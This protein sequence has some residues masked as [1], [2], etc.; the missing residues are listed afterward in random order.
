MPPP[1]PGHS[2][3]TTLPQR[4]DWGKMRGRGRQWPPHPTPPASPSQTAGMLQSS[5]QLR[6]AGLASCQAHT[7]TGRPWVGVLWG[8][9]VGMGL[10]SLSSL[11]PPHLS[12]PPRGGGQL[13]TAPAP[14]PPQCLSQTR[15][16]L[17]ES[18]RHR[19]ARRHT[20]PGLPRQWHWEQ[21]VHWG[22]CARTGDR[23]LSTM[24]GR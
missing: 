17:V 20:S 22:G 11:L 7:A 15:V 19:G 16:C 9:A 12:L 5:S 24:L 8:E 3:F 2:S 13:G 23:S 4:P 6:S 18:P 14:L 10:P 1:A 21:C